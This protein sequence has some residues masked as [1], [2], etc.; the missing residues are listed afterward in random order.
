MR[1]PKRV[2]GQCDLLA[3]S[4]TISQTLTLPHFTRQRIDEGAGQLY[5]LP[6]LFDRFQERLAIPNVAAKHLRRDLNPRLQK[7]V[8][9]LRQIR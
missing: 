6:V 3:L 4:K 8:R 9:S 2:G 7:N 1:C 5:D